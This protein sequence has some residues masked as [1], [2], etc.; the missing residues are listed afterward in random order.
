MLDRKVHVEVPSA[1]EGVSVKSMADHSARVRSES[2]GQCTT[3]VNSKSA[4]ASA[5]LL[6]LLIFLKAQKFCQLTRLR[7]GPIYAALHCP[8]GM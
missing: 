7:D 1:V 4:T 2:D 6:N 3:Q 5:G 8:I